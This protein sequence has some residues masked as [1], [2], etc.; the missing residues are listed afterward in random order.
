M[1][2]VST[3]ACTPLSLCASIR[4]RFKFSVR[5]LQEFFVPIANIYIHAIFYEQAYKKTQADSCPYIK[6]KLK[7]ITW[8]RF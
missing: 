2:I 8:L 5:A 4:A 7:T 6:N 3:T 1:S